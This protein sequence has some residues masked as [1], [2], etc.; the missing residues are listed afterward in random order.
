MTT[1]ELTPKEKI[2]LF[3]L[4][5][6]DSDSLWLPA[7]RKVREQFNIEDFRLLIRSLLSQNNDNPAAMKRI[8]GPAYESVVVLKESSNQ[9]QYGEGNQIKRRESRDYYRSI[10]QE[11]VCCEG[12]Q[13]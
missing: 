12:S 7:I 3:A 4:D 6:I 1:T 10:T 8:L 2:A 13:E 11:K 9:S 5:F